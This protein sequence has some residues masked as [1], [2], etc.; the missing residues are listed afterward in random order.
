MTD[1]NI[2]P[3]LE[4]DIPALADLHFYMWNEFYAGFLPA[5]YAQKNYTLPQCIKI[6]ENMIAACR[7]HPSQHFARVVMDGSRLAA[8]GYISPPQ[9]Y[10]GGLSVA[11][12]DAEFQ[13][14]YLYPDYRG[15]GLGS[16]MMTLGMG[17]LAEHNLRSAYLWAF[18][19]N[20]Y[21][22]F[23]TKLGAQAVK[24]LTRDYDGIPLNLTAYGWH[25][26]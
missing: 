25:L 19:Q 18:D 15:A 23:Y 6:Q 13:R 1:F 12:F 3:P 8:V 4:T 26:P 10:G 7:T 2:R 14:I 22:G 5:S 17:W 9:D 20:P 24:H 21:T 16:R 11:G